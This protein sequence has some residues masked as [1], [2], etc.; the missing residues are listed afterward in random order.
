FCGFQRFLIR[1][2]IVT[3]LFIAIFFYCMEHFDRYK[4]AP[5]FILPFIQ[6]LWSNMHGLYILGILFMAL[7]LLGEISNILIFRFLGKL[8]QKKFDIQQWTRRGACFLLVCVASLLNANGKDGILYPYTIFQEIF[9]KATSPISTVG[10]LVSP[11]A[12]PN[13][14]F[15]NPV[16]L[17][18]LFVLL[19]IVALI[20]NIKRLR[21]CYLL[22]FCAFFFLAVLSFRNIAIFALMAMP[23]TVYNIAGIIDYFKLKKRP[24]FLP[25]PHG[26]NAALVIIIVISNILIMIL[27]AN[28]HIYKR[29]GYHRKFGF[30]ISEFF[31]QEAAEYIKN[32]TN[33]I[34]GNI[35]NS[36][37]IGGYLIWQLYPERKVSLDGRWE[38]YGDFINNIRKFSDRN[39]F[40]QIVKKY[41]IT[42]L[43][44]G[45]T[46][47]ELH[48][49]RW[50][51]SRDPY[52]RFVKETKN[53]YIF[54]RLYF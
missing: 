38:V 5:F 53:T 15:P 6:V 36:A 16:I 21:F 49:V 14:P 20:F 48:L 52:W 27:I 4:Y 1:P 54:K 10:E 37:D 22:P 9:S 26:I 45:K 41:N 46:A 33:A 44:L 30:G 39:Y 34:K 18:K 2:E 3:F 40:M 23:M 32:P 51:L 12:F 50:W 35:F 24:R 29:L 42:L 28:N 47:Q 11:F 17:F 25:S 13:V 43:V 7:Y 19:S 8:E 31:P